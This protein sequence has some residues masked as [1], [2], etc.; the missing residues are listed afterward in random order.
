MS[1]TLLLIN[2]KLRPASNGATFVRH[3]FVADTVATTAAAATLEDTASAVDAAAQAF[4]GWSRSGPDYRRKLLLEAASEL[5][6]LSAELT[7]AMA[8]E[9]GATQGW[10]TFNIALGA[11]ILREAASLTTA[12]RGE[13]IPSDM[14]GCFSMSIRQAA[15][16]VL[17]IAPWN[18]P[19]ILG[20]RAI[21]TALACGNSVILKASEACP[22]THSLIGQAFLRA[23]FPK[24][25][26]NVLSNAPEDAGAIV[27]ALIDAPAVRR[28]NFTG[29]TRVG[30]LIAERCGRQL[31]PALL[32]L[33]GKAPLLVLDDADLETAVDAAI[34]GAFMNQGQ[35]CM[36]TERVIVTP[37]IA[38][39]FVER[40][41]QRAMA[42]RADDP[43]KHSTPLGSIIDPQAAERVRALIANAL[44]A[45]ATR[46]AGDDGEGVLIPANVIDRVTPA[47]QLYT[48]E[49]FGPVV[50]VIRAKDQEDA[51]RIANDS[52]YGLSAAVFTRDIS[53]AM[54]VAG[55]IRSGICHI[56]GAT[57]HDEPQAPFGGLG[58]SGHGRFGGEAGVAE[59][60]DLRWMTIQQ[61]PR[62]YP[63]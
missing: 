23:G 36:S 37:G 50:S 38:E 60:T 47:M 3:D 45:G 5:L 10:A 24:G 51:I 29:S 8:R 49:S 62:R 43:R 2:G 25:V 52:E 26:V 21:A 32:E 20:V 56:N 42:L 33:G 53:R 4:V 58:A 46:L 40:L 61:Q 35:I 27:N 30:R 31:K 22:Q 19:V 41:A 57:V 63:L 17:G 6:G 54:D 39:A 18:A 12:V 11:S 48:Q 1:N 15:G 34:F 16:V 59:F 7:A 44:A 13:T 28:V 55:R 14:P 9:T